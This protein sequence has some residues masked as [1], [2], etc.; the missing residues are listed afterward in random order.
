VS[1]LQKHDRIPTVDFRPFLA[2]G[3]R[4]TAE[5]VAQLGGYLQHFG[6][7]SLVGHGVPKAV[8]AD[9]FAAAASF[10]SQAEDIK[11]KVQ[12]QRNNRG[13]IPMFDSLSKDQKPN[14]LEAFSI[15]HPDLPRD[16]ELLALPFYAP[17]PWP[18][19]VNFR[20]RIEPCYRALYSVGEALMRAIAVHLGAAPNFFAE[21][22]KQTYS[23]MR[24]IHYPPQETVADIAAFGV[25]AHIDRGL[26]TLLVQDMNGGLSVRAPEG[27]WLPVVPDPEAIVVNV[28]SLLRRWTNGRYAA[29][30]HQVVNSSGRER[31]SMPLFVH[32]SFHTM[33]DPRSLVGETPASAEFEPIVAG[34][35]VFAGFVKNRPSWSATVATAG[36]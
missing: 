20:E 6:F 22:A 17:T 33:I 13:Y 11:K 3:D 30:L 36:G 8:L 2:A 7:V 18:E 1:P 16:P 26:L 34:E 5:S 27:D 23:N 9:A 15:G 31:Y 19:L 10:F 35:E 12:D 25:N 21:M 4:P 14:G 28:G 29:A 24:V 32:P